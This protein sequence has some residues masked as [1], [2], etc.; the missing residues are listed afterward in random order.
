MP[1]SKF[2]VFI[3]AIRLQFGDES[4]DVKGCEWLTTSGWFLY[5]PLL[6]PWVRDAVCFGDSD[7]AEDLADVWSW[8]Q[9]VAQGWYQSFQK[10]RQWGQIGLQC[11]IFL[12]SNIQWQYWIIETTSLIPTM[13]A[14]GYRERLIYGLVA[15]QTRQRAGGLGVM[16]GCFTDQDSQRVFSALSLIDLVIFHIN[17]GTDKYLE[18]LLH[19]K[20]KCQKTLDGHRNSAI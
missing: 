14:L 7:G 1:C 17:W 11:L 10:C 16:Y 5:Y 12:Y 13:T 19:C 8:A 18:L 15:V 4:L 3:W 2:H 6:L 20:L 9:G